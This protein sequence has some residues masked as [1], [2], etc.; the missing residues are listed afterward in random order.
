MQTYSPGLTNTIPTQFPAISS[1]FTPAVYG[2]PVSQQ[3]NFT[4]TNSRLPTKVRLTL[5][6]SFI[7]GNLSCNSFIDFTGSCSI[8][9]TNT[10]EVAG[11][12]SSAPM[13]FSV[14]GVTSPTSAPSDYS[15]MVTFDSGGYKID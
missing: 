7:I 13:A 15:S 8:V 1:Q 6:N 11:T 14:T 5:A 3:I 9:S 2:E 10:I 12:F 4:L